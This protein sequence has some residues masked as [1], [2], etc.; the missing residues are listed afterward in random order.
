MTIDMTKGSVTKQIIRFSIPVFLG[1]L[2]QQVYNL[3]DTIIVGRL[4]GVNALAGVGSTTGLW[5]L[6]FSVCNGFCNGFSVSVSQ[7]FG[8]KDEDGLKKYFGNAIC[9]AI[10]SAL[11]F[12]VVSVLS[13]VPI[14]KV[15]NTPEDIYG[16]AYDYI[17][18]LLFGIPCT[19]FY[20]LLAASQRAIGDSKTPVIA[21]V[22]SSVI[23]II[24]DFV[25]IKYLSMGTSGAA[26]ATVIS[27][28]ISGLYLLWFVSKKVPILHVKG[29]VKLDWG[30]SREQLGTAVPMALQG[31]VI[32]FG[33]LIVQSAV[34][35]LGTIYVAGSTAGNKLYGI[36][37]AP[38]DSLCQ[39]MIPVSGQNYG[40][41]EYKRIDTGLK[42]V[43]QMT[44]GITLILIV[45]AYFFGPAMINVF[46][47]PENGI[48]ITTIIRYGHQFL[49][50][51]VCGYGFLAIQESCCFTLQGIGAAKYT[52]LS[53][54][55][56]TAG[57]LVGALLITKYFGYT[58][59]C[60]ALPLAWVFTSI[61]VIP[62]YLTQR[63]RLEITTT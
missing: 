59:I 40:A 48:D 51:F 56:E 4:L 60:L 19:F 13:A 38:I 3:A 37:A 26:W 8:T 27:Q 52:I 57:R 47:S 35:S 33:I 7:K 42:R 63:R 17:I 44:W 11:L 24:L 20:N 14:L 12:T 32:A 43:L 28:L 2:F 15:T 6:V 22:I 21:L 31:A 55:L 16:Y 25:F 30:R 61:Y 36:M 5:F 62:V 45:I 41:G 1:S 39:S 29:Y 53:G 18:V 9:L 46:L 34:N 10:I 23:N 54:V 50:Y 58:G 49:L